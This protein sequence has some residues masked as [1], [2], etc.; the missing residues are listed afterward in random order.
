MLVELFCKQRFTLQGNAYSIL[1]LKF[2]DVIKTLKFYNLNRFLV[3]NIDYSPWLPILIQQ[4][5]VNI[6]NTMIL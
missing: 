5:V 6:V 4:I 2:L 1:N 3:Q